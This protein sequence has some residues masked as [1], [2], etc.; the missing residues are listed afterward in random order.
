VGGDF[1]GFVVARD[2]KRAKMQGFAN[3]EDAYAH[4]WIEASGR[5]IDLGAYFLPDDSGFNAASMPAVAW[6]LTY[7][8]PRFLR[9]R[10]LGRSGNAGVLS[11]DPA[12]N[13]RCVKFAE[14]CLNN[15]LHEKNS[16]FPTWIVTNPSSVEIAANR[17]TLW[18]H[19]AMRFARRDDPRD[20]PF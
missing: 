10:A 8:L 5:L 4:Y 9:Y 3:S 7:P 14:R 2:G 1:V 16:K 18:A 20:L 19:A 13:E 12:I 6:D 11:S 15:A 17:K